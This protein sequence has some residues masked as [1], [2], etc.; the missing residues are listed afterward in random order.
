MSRKLTIR[1]ISLCWQKELHGQ[2]PLSLW[3]IGD[4]LDDFRHRSATLAEKEELV[5]DAPVIISDE[6]HASCNAYLA[7]VAETLCREVSLPVP[8][9]TESRQYFLHRPWFAGGLETL[10]AL[11]LTESPVPFRRRNLFVSANALSR[12]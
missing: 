8:L 3:M 2:R 12:V 4:L 6:E 1:E 10:K 9:W 7:A 11:L 5:R